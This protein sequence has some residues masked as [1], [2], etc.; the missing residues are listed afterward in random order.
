M[1][2]CL[3]FYKAFQLGNCGPD[4][5]DRNIHIAALG[6]HIA[7]RSVEPLKLP[8]DIFFGIIAFASNEHRGVA[9]VF[10]LQP[11]AEQPQF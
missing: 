10:Q 7:G 6:V 5:M 4:Q 2:L 1:G 3:L 9:P 8:L 11:T